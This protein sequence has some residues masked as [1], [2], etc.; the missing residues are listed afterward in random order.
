[1]FYKYSKTE[2]SHSTRKPEAGERSKYLGKKVVAQGTS[3]VLEQW[4]LD[5]VARFRHDVRVAPGWDEGVVAKRLFA[6]IVGEERRARG[7]I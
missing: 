7:E 4:H 3:L 1:L 5:I 2:S 6:I